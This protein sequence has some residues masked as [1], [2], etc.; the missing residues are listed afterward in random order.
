MADDKYQPRRAR[1]ARFYQ[2]ENLHSKTELT[3]SKSASHH[4]ITVLRTRKNDVIELFNGDGHNYRATVIETG[5]RAQGKCA[6]LQLHERI[7]VLNESPLSITLVQAISRADRMDVTLRQAVELGVHHIQPIYSHHSA[8]PLDDTRAS[9]KQEHWQSIVISACEQSGR[10]VLPTLATP[11]TLSYWLDLRQANNTTKQDYILAPTA[12]QS[13]LSHIS[14][15][16][17]ISTPIGLLIG[18]ESGFNEDEIINAQNAGVQA[19]RFGPR[20]LRTETAGPAAITLLQTS[21][22]DLGQDKT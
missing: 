15:T 9:K 18:P 20:I 21:L 5:Q 7:A 11:V 2:A 13:L 16:A 3:L 8:K 17:S 4:L 22:G 19:V 6:Q 10:A 12:P 1:T 14:N